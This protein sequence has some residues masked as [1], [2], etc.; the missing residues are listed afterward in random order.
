MKISAVRATPIL[1]PLE[2]PYV[3]SYGLL[4]GFT[5]CLVEVETSDGVTGIGEAPSHAAAS[6]VEAWAETL[7]GRD[8][9]DIAGLERLLLPS[10]PFSHSVTDYTTRGAW[11]RP[12]NP[13]FGICA[14]SFGVSPWPTS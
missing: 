6:I 12:G 14:A 9:L 5:K 2:A 8:P 3:W 7:I 11:W 13:P 1:V 4:D 10:M